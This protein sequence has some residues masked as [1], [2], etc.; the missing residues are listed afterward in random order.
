LKV[1]L[2]LLRP[3]L[4]HSK[5]WVE[6]TPPPPPSP[7]RRRQQPIHSNS[8]LEVQYT[9]HLSLATSAQKG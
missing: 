2:L 4:G 8:G 3:L 5:M 6:G 7:A 1:P 9:L